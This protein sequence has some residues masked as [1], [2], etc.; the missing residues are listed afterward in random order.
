[1]STMKILLV[2]WL[3]LA[4]LIAPLSGGAAE[5]IAV[6]GT[7]EVGGALGPELAS[8][9]HTIIYGSRE[10]ERDGVVELVARTGNDASATTPERAASA[11]GIVI[12]AVP[13]LMVEPI[14][15]GLGDLSGK[16]IIDPTNALRR[17]K[18]G[19]LEMAVESSN[20]E[21]IQNAAPGAYVVKAFNTLNWR[22]MVDPESSGGPI[23]IPLVGDNADAKVRV[24]ALATELGLEPIDLGPLKYARY[25]EGMLILWINSEEHFEYH[26]RR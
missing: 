19:S 18:D 21:L 16:I 4:A 23:S 20:A 25:V 11:A 9:G 12:L 17:G 22:Q 8:L 6:I 13:G 5:T 24:A 3:S 2:V 26:L 14:T 15:Q 10:P 7:G 1:M